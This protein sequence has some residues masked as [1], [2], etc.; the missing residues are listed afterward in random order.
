[1]GVDD[2]DVWSKRGDGREN[3]TGKWARD[4]GDG[5]TMCACIGTGVCAQYGKGKS[6]CTGDDTIRQ[7]S[8]GMF[9]EFQ[10]SRPIVF[11]GVAKSVQGTYPWISSPRKDQFSRTPSTNQL[12][13]N[14]IG[15]EANQGEVSTSLPNDLVSRGEGNE[16]RETLERDKIAIMDVR[17]NGGLH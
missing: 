5:R 12:V 13:A 7:T 17:R 3:L 9:V 11:N 16:V 4:S 1:L 8:V 10:C 14:E 15:R 6:S 2:S